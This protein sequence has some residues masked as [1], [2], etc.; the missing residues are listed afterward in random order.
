MVGTPDTISMGFVYIDAFKSKLERE[1]ERLEGGLLLA[2]E[3]TGISDRTLRR[4]LSGKQHS[5]NEHLFDQ[6]ATAF[7]WEPWQFKIHGLKDDDD[8]KH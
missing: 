5:V 1:I 2:A 3:I 6:I 4:I 7:E 8:K